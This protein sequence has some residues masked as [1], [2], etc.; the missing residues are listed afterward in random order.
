MTSSTLRL[1]PRRSLGFW[2]LLALLYIV[3]FFF[4][5]RV[6]MWIAGHRGGEIGAPLRETQ[7]GRYLSARLA[8]NSGQMEDALRLNLAAL[9]SDPANKYLMAEV[10][11][12]ALFAG[13]AKVLQ[14]F[15]AQLPAEAEP[16]LPP[17]FV[18]AM[19]DFAKGDYANAQL[20]LKTL[21][22]KGFSVAFQPLFLAWADAGA[23][24]LESPAAVPPFALQSPELAALMA[25][26]VALI[27]EYAGYHEEAAIEYAK[28]EKQASNLPNRPMQGLIN[29]LERQNRTEAAVA[30][31]SA[32]R[33]RH[34]DNIIRLDTALPR[35]LVSTPAEGVAELLYGMASIF[36]SMQAEA[37]ATAHLRLALML[38]PDFAPAH[39][40][41]GMLLEQGKQF[42]GARKE[43]E[44]V[45]SSDP[46]YRTTR[47][48]LA[49]IEH[50]RGEDNAAF[51]TLDKLQKFDPT[52][53]SALSAKGDLLR[54]KQDYKGAVSAYTQAL[55]RLPK[56]LPQHWQI[57]YARGIAY[58][59]ARMWAKAEADF[60]KA[61]EL[62]PRNAEVENYL[63]YSWLAQGLN[64]ERAKALIA[65]ALTQQPNSPAIID[66]MAWGLQMSGQSKEALPFAEQAL[67]MM[68]KDATINEHLGD[69]YWR[70]GRETEAQ[71]Q[72][73]RALLFK[74][75]EPGQKEGLERKLRE[76][77][78]ALKAA[79]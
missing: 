5:L 32:H 77:L 28:L 43:Y 62:S 58:E 20:H 13:D 76:G 50:A 47:L 78:P 36:M 48:R 29:Y 60:L 27:D 41:L 57:L 21:P 49:M 69:I 34:P 23:K 26:H 39:T 12:T 7:T 54:D 71:Y 75:T 40:M 16:A 44:L 9:K 22:A 79:Q 18:Q 8:H 59:R 17:P 33:K 73:Q 52:D 35:P 68:P 6:S 30:A 37:E 67:D 45:P 38:R 42:D 64:V 61:L 56:L 3:A 10:Y 63:G 4:G 15:A 74:P 14:Q 51:A 1:R 24:T 25:Y 65:D 46:L 11:R 53:T 55:A 31:L 70:L 2:L 66:S 72:W 19:G